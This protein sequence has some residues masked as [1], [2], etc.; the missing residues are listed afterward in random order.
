MKK[1]KFILYS[2]ITLTVVFSGC[3]KKDNPLDKEQYIKQVYLVGA[4]SSNNEGRT[5][6][7]ANY[8]NG[9][10]AEAS[11]NLSVATGGSLNIDRD[12]TATIADAGLAQI[13]RYNSLY[14]YRSTDIKIRKLNDLFYR[15]PSKN[16]LIKA[17]EVNGTTPVYVK[18]A[19][20]QPD[21]LYAF[22]VKIASV[23]EPDYISMRKTDT[24]LMVSL[25][26]INA[27]SDYTYKVV[28]TYYPLNTP[29]SVSS[30]SL[31]ARQLKA[32]NYNTVRFYHLDNKEEYA[33]IAPF[34]VKMQVAIDNTLIISAWG[35]LNVTAGGGTYNPDT[36]TF[37]AWYNYVVSG[38]TYQFKGTFTATV[39][40]A[41]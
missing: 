14:L 11:F 21:S 3:K 2:F 18:T 7:K 37:N 4:N 8:L 34:G 23:S 19:G 17:N 9:A 29:T 38:V 28:G 24:V 30:V 25:N 40:P 13:T 20:L 26:L 31:T 33:N 1:L 10:D 5:I 6:I 36:K 12:V 32:T 15:I 16:V 27:Y 35:T 22:S 41:V 39:P